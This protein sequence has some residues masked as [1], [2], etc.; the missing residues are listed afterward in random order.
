[1]SSSDESRRRYLTIA[2]IDPVTRSGCEVLISFDRMQ[3]VARRSLAH[4]KECGLIVPF[5]LQQPTAVFEGLRQD[6]D[7]SRFRSRVL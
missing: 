1:M 4:A 7:A 6:E 3:S 5:I 2:A